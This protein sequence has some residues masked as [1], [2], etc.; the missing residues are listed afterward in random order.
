MSDGWTL[1]Y[2]LKRD[3]KGDK[4]GV[5]IKKYLIMHSWVLGINE[6]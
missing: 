5:Y 1:G 6:R 2:N 4:E 3:S